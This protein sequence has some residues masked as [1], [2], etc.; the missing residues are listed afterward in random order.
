M[1]K[2][3]IIS[4]TV[5]GLLSFASLNAADNISEMFSE[6]KVSGQFRAFYI[7]RKYQG[8][9]GNG[10][11]RNGTAVG[12][13]LKYVTD[14]YLGLSFGGAFYHTQ[15][16]FLDNPKNNYAH[17]DP[18]LFG[19]DNE[20]Y[21]ILGESYVNFKYANTSFK[22]GRM[23][24][25]TPMMFPDDSRM[26]PNL[27]QAYI[28][29]NKDIKDTT[30]TVGHVT[31]FAQGTFGRVN[32]SGIS[33]ATA[34]YSAIDARGQVGDFSNIGTY[35][36][37]KS[38]DGVTMV[39]A[40]YNGIENLKLELWDFYGHDI[41]NVIYGEAQYTFKD[42]F[43]EPSVSAQFIKQNDVGDSIVKNAMGGDGEIDSFYWAAKIGL[44]YN[45]FKVSV[46]HSQTTDNDAGDSSYENAIIS[47]WGGMPSYTYAMVV[48]HQFF[49][50]TNA[51]KVVGSYSFKEQGVNL[52][53]AVYHGSYDMDE[54]SG[55]GVER[56]TTEAGFDIKYYPA[57]VKNLQLRLRAN[58]P[59][60]F[61][62]TTSGST[63]WNEYRFIMNYNF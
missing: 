46:A 19:K 62:E 51:T 53:T 41:L 63:G 48:R 28:L 30:L 61:G 34:G 35:S 18:S 14:D 54:N 36:F 52:S 47:A 2:N 60:K 8:S 4:T 38:T 21:T 23:K 9:A 37:G 5:F 12:G 20:S 15:G 25:K 29:T 24:L 42:T 33:S 39:S 45:G 32:Q 49:A 50:G 56:T 3:T 10:V 7:D 11:H 17:N 57:E 26:I 27:Y 43:L 44:K 1:K 31:K 40:S 13:Y 58:Y 55:F 16:L 22:G 6:G 59:R